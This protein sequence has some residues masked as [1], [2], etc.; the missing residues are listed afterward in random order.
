M[1]V[2]IFFY[3]LVLWSICEGEELSQQHYQVCSKLTGVQ[4][5]DWSSI[6]KKRVIQKARKVVS[7]PDHILS[8]EFCLMSSG[9]RYLLPEDWAACERFRMEEEPLQHPRPRFVTCRFFG[10]EPLEGSENSLNIATKS[11][12]SKSCNMVM[13]P[14]YG[15]W[16]L[17]S[18]QQLSEPS[19]ASNNGL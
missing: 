18:H 7:H 8:Q 6:W 1:S 16:R 10:K 13:T 4:L 5:T 19:S 9:Q 2:D 11:L 15:W 17:H 12:S 14:P 3:L